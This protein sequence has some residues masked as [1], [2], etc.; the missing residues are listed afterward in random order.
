[1]KTG[2]SLGFWL[3]LLALLAAGGFGF[4]GQREKG[5]LLQAKLTLIREEVREVERLQ[6]ENLRLRG[7][8]IPAAQLAALREDHA[9]VLRLRAELAFLQKQAAAR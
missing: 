6:A 4:A 7:Q 3:L 8:Q 5:D 1:M 9:A 2:S